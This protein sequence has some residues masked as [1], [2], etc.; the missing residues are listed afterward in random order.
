MAESLIGELA[1]LGKIYITL[2][3]PFVLFHI[4]ARPSPPV[5]LLPV[6]YNSIVRVF[7]ALGFLNLL[8][9]SS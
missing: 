8:L 2:S 3:L 5:L 7:S 4:K 1:E 9:L 6:Y